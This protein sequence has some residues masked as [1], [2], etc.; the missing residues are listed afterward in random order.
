LNGSDVTKI[1]NQSGE[2]FYGPLAL[3]GWRQCARFQATATGRGSAGQGLHQLI[4]SPGC[5][6]WTKACAL[7]PTTQWN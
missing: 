4:A 3:T 7:P 5:A 6:G 2:K 1:E